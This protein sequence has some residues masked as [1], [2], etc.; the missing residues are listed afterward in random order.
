M[1]SV[2]RLMRAACLKHTL[3]KWVDRMKRMEG[4]ALLLGA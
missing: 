3:Q 1:D 2:G 4:Q